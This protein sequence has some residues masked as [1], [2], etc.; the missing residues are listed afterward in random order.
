MLHAVNITIPA[1]MYNAHQ[2]LCTDEMAALKDES[3]ATKC[4][5]RP[6]IFSSIPTIIHEIRSV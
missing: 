5:P 3:E 4:P 2:Q 1:A 6:S